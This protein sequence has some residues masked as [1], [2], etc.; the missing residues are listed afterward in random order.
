MTNFLT[1]EENQFMTQA[2]RHDIGGYDNWHKTPRLRPFVVNIDARPL[3]ALINTAAFGVRVYEFMAIQRPGDLLHYLWVTIVDLDDEVIQSVKDSVAYRNPYA[4]DKNAPLSGLSFVE[5]D[6]CF[7]WQGDDTDL[8]DACWRRHVEQQSWLDKLSHLFSL[9][10][11]LQQ[12]LRAMDDFLLQNEIKLIDDKK[13][14]KDFFATVN[15]YCALEPHELLV[16]ATK[17]AELYKVLADVIAQNEVHSVSCPFGGLNIWRIFVEEQIKRAQKLVLPPQE[18]FSLYGPDSGLNN[19][20]EDWGGYVHIPCEGMC[21]GDVIFLP[22]WRVFHA[23]KAGAD[24]SLAAALRMKLCR[25][26]FVPKE[27]GLGELA[28]ATREE[29]GNWV[30]Y[31]DKQNVKASSSSQ[32]NELSLSIKKAAKLI[33]EADAI[34]IT[35]GAGMGVDS[36]LPDFRGNDGFWNAYPALAK[37]NIKFY[38]IASP[39][40]FERDPKLAWGFY[41]HRLN[42]YRN[43]KPHTGFR[44]LHEIAANKEHGY[45]VFTSN[46]DGHF[47]KAGFDPKRICECHGSI[48]HLQC[49]NGCLHHIWDAGEFTPEVDEENCQ[50]LNEP[51]KCSCCGDIARPNILMFNDFKWEDSRFKMQRQALSEWLVRTKR[52]V[53]IELGAGQDIP[54]VRHYGETLGWPLIRINPRDPD[55]GSSSGVS[56]P[57]GA[58]AALNAIYS[59]LN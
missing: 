45:F 53:I 48:H 19:L 9:V 28:C 30:L 49:I 36:G 58:L 21:D 23:E 54:T 50:L 26:L 7:I 25:Y 51:P 29:I 18:A 16:D 6:Q 59:A 39:N 31:R 38:D 44:M 56:L 10:V 13:H 2:E 4:F 24:G 40:N 27:R 8:E 15:R 52:V 1:A 57:M 34:L 47:R 42:L 33:S 55:L 11:T 5:F 3:A 41:G 37:A 22:N 20:P 12:R 46:V 43:T 32:S 14:Q 17:S 35:A